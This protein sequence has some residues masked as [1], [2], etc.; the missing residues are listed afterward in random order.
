[1]CSRASKNEIVG[2]PP[3]AACAVIAEKGLVKALKTYGSQEVAANIAVNPEETLFR[4]DALSGML[5]RLAILKLASDGKIA[6]TEPISK[7]FEVKKF[8]T[9]SDKNIPTKIAARWIIRSDKETKNQ[10]QIESMIKLLEDRLLILKLNKDDFEYDNDISSNP[11]VNIFFDSKGNCWFLD[12]KFKKIYNQYTEENILEY[13]KN[14]PISKLQKVDSDLVWEWGEIWHLNNIDHTYLE[15]LN[16]A[17][18]SGE[19]TILNLMLSTSGIDFESSYTSA[20]SKDNVMSLEEF[21]K[22]HPPRVIRQ[23]GDFCVD[24]PY[25]TVLLGRI[26]EIVSGKPFE[27]YMQDEIFAPLGMTKTTFSQ[28]ENGTPNLAKPRNWV[29]KPKDEIGHY[30]EIPQYFTN[31]AP[32]NSLKTTANDMSR[33]MVYLSDMFA[34]DGL[35]IID[36]APEGEQYTVRLN[37][38]R[39]D[40]TG[41]TGSATNLIKPEYFALIGTGLFDSFTGPSLSRTPLFYKYEHN[42]KN[43][44]IYVCSLQSYN[45]GYGMSFVLIPDKSISI[46]GACAGRGMWQFE[47]EFYGKFFPQ[48]I[49]TE[50]R[51][52]PKVKIP[53]PERYKGEWSS[54]SQMNTPAKAEQL[55]DYHTR[56]YVENDYLNCY[57]REYVMVDD[58]TFI[59]RY[60][61]ND[62]IKFIEDSSGNIAYIGN[63]NPKEKVPFIGT[64]NFNI[65]FMLFGLFV[66]LTG[67]FGFLIGAFL[68]KSKGEKSTLV[69]WLAR[70]NVGVNTGLTVII[71]VGMVLAMMFVRLEDYLFGMQWWA[72]LGLALALIA[73]LLALSM[74]Y[75]IF[76]IWKNKL[77]SVSS[78]I[79]YTILTAFFLFAPYWLWYWNLLGFTY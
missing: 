71:G 15:S 6:L 62:K 33:F 43:G 41:A 58:L 30:E 52:N 31:I 56:T 51:E 70:V 68:R 24:N 3:P 27:K 35:F 59:G 22:S 32:A 17:T 46:F 73:S 61:A 1:L 29:K 67:L 65:G 37:A 72:N 48:K 64:N 79:H 23:P 19:I 11:Y 77:W 38:K 5:T 69:E 20:I 78:R 54:F 8:Y 13:N 18:Q 44:P 66:I 9:K 74:A 63:F 7:H 53:N 34:F 14:Y 40:E 47:S 45:N 36:E 60:N 57:G 28:P 21:I 16:N 49:D 50:C 10:L 42:Y 4:A 25:E 12:S 2:N 39:L 55:I 26:I 75:F 76:I